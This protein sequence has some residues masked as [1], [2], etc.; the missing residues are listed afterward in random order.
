[1]EPIL[2]ASIFIVTATVSYAYGTLMCI[3]YMKDKEK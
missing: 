2:E 3:I 1:M